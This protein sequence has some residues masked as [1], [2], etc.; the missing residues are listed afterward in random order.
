MY[1]S[2]FNYFRFFTKQLL[3]NKKKYTH[4]GDKVFF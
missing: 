2:R 3:L 4:Y 1:S